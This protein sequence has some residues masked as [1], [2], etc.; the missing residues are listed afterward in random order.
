MTS[1]LKELQLA[2]DGYT[3]TVKPEVVVE[4]AHN[5]IQRSPQYSSGFARI[6]RI[7]D[8]KSVEQATTLSQLQAPYER[9]F[10]SKSRR[11]I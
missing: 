9:Q 2:D 11:E 1:R 8:D 5:E 7:R 4:V 3:V 10:V 6:T